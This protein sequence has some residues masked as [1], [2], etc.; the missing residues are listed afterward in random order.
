MKLKAHKVGQDAWAK[1]VTIRF[2]LRPARFGATGHVPAREPWSYLR[3]WIRANSHHSTRV[4]AGVFLDQSESFAKAA[5]SASIDTAPLL[6]YYSFL[7]LAKC[8]LAASNKESIADLGNA[9][10]GIGEPGGNAG[11]YLK[12]SKQ[13]VSVWSK[14]DTKNNLQIFP[15]L[16]DA[17][18]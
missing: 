14:R 5:Q 12:L 1:G 7:N 2:S 11:G 10:H 16:C 8:Y 3:Y 15:A 9:R 18:N 17:L 6:W 13:K 4:A